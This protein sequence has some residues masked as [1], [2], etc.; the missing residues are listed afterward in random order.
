V[1]SLDDLIGPI[2]IIFNDDPPLCL[3]VV[4]ETHQLYLS[5]THIDAS[6]NR[7]QMLEP[8]H[9]TQVFI[10]QRISTSGG[11]SIK[12]VEGKYLS[13]D[14]FGVVS[15]D[16]EAVGPTEEWQPILREDGIAWQSVY[17]KFLSVDLKESNQDNTQEKARATEATM[18]GRGRIRTMSGPR[19][20]ADAE[21]I[22][23]TE[24]FI[25][26]CQAELRKRK[27]TTPSTTELVEDIQTFAQEQARRYQSG[28]VIHLTEEEERELKRARRQGQLAQALLDRR[29]KSK[30]DRYCK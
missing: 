15:C 12:S 2:Y 22:T 11:F 16:K 21:T 18:S 27:R 5:P 29:E 30:S 10:G 20:R 9:V 26:K 1:T 3:A 13:T 23:F 4:E 19:L 7:L 14:K 28:K 17:G 25:I 24:V 8:D 6:E